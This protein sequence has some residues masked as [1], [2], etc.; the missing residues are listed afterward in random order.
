MMNRV[1]LPT[2]Y[3]YSYLPVIGVHLTMHL[4]HP[5][6]WQITMRML[7]VSEAQSHPIIQKRSNHQLAMVPKKNAIECATIIYILYTLYEHA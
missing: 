3:Y 7:I 6:N 2:K 1:Q 5:N 4:M